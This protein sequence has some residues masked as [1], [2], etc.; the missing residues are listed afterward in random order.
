M[1]DEQN[2]SKSKLIK[3]L[4]RLKF[5]ATKIKKQCSPIQTRSEPDLL[6]YLQNADLNKQGRNNMVQTNQMADLSGFQN[7]SKELD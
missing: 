7:K 6:S 5:K 1:N 3:N 4:P 2:D